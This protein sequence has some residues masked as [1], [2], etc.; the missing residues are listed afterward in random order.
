MDTLNNKLFNIIEKEMTSKLKGGVWICEWH[1]T[2]HHYKCG[3]EMRDDKSGMD[4]G[5]CIAGGTSTGSGSGYEEGD[6]I[7]YADITQEFVDFDTNFVG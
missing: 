1:R 2:I 3:S 6:L 5:Q 7:S 4:D